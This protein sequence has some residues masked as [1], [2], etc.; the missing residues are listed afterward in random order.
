MIVV[1][2]IGIL[3]AIALPQYQ[4]YTARAQTTEAMNLLAGLKTPLMDISGASGLANA[5]STNASVPAVPPTNPDG[6]GG[7]PA[8]VAGAL[9]AENNYTLAGKYV[10]GI[11]ATANGTTDCALT[12]TFK[13]T[14]VNDKLISKKIIFKYTASTAS[15][16]CTSDLDPSVRPKT[17]DAAS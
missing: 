6:T 5:C 8:V 13:S 3:A 4:N 11:T 9:A 10:G 14:G 12:A 2:I 1:A 16:A 17:C 7:T 15:W